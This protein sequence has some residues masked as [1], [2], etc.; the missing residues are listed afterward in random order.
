MSGPKLVS[1]YS[2]SAWRLTQ[3]VY[4][5][6]FSSIVRHV[7][8]MRGRGFELNQYDPCVAN[9]IIGGK[10]MIFCWYVDVLKVSHVD[11]KE[12]TNFM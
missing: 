11:L 3:S 7:A 8:D 1:H 5:C 2:P 10:H 6:T 4:D 12:V 9:K